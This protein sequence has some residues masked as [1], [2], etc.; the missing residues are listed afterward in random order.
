MT[1]VE[2]LHR[3]SGYS[4]LRVHEDVSSSTFWCHM[5]SRRFPNDLAYRPCFS[6]R[7]L[8]ELRDFQLRTAEAMRRPTHI[9]KPHV[10]SHVVVA[11]AADVYNLG[12]DLDLFCRLIRAQDRNSLMAYAR[13]CV[14]VAYAF[15]RHLNEDAHTVALV[16]GDALGGGF[17]LALCCQTIVAESGVGMGFPEVLFDLFPGMGAYSFLRRRISSS[18][19]QQMMLDGRVYSSD[20][21]HAMGVVD[22]LVPKGEGVAAVQDL[23][24]RNQRI[25]HAR[26][27]MNRV[28]SVCHPVSFEEL[29]TVTEIW[30]DT[31][32]QLGEK[33]LRVMERLVRAQLRRN[34]ATPIRPVAATSEA[35]QISN[36]G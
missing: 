18:Q 2:L 7:L 6:T 30:V 31:A 16:Q 5:H 33:S 34:Q 21:L 17:E 36:V 25:G 3:D 35:V 4:T 11:S 19:A 8:K 20:E 32:L 27:A 23:V 1:N 9:Q 10:L 14:E 26:L 15:Y 12:G 29:M 13:Q 22:I 28:E 24:K